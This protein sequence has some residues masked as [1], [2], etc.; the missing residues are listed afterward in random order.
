[1]KPANSTRIPAAFLLTAL[2]ALSGCTLNSAPP[3]AA[4][5]ETADRIEGLRRFDLVAKDI[6]RGSQPDA[7]QLQKII[8][9]HGVKTVIK[10]NSGSE[11]DVP[12]VNVIRHYFNAWITP[13]AEEIQGILKDIDKAE[14]PVFIHCTYGEDRTGLI[15]GLYKVR[16]LKVST[17]DAY[18]DMSAHGFHPYPGVWKAWVRDNGWTPGSPVAQSA[19]SASVKARA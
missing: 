7:G 13:S 1:M 3:P 12:G 9:A 14:K 18:R 2:I 5:L 4:S 15:V 6:Y 8:A 17:E 10:L 11:P 19:R 16:Y